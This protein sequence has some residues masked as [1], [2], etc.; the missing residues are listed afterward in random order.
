[1]ES[2]NPLQAVDQ[3]SVTGTGQD[4]MRMTCHG[5]CHNPFNHPEKP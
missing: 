3:R 2:S 4:G 5:K 1:V